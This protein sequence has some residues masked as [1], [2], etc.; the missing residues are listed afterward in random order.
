MAYDLSLAERIRRI[1]RRRRGITEKKMFG[2]LAFLV[3]GNMFCGIV[4]R[5]LMVRVGPDAYEDALAQP[6]A[7]VMDFT[8]K[9]LRGYVYVG[10][11]GIREDDDLGRWVSRGHAFGRTLPKK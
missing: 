4:D 8:G 6:S 10:A 5:E 1:L 3:N 7:R 11:A 2:G 9:P